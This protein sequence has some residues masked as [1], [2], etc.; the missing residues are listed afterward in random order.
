MLTGLG[1]ILM[2]V[3]SVMMWWRRRPQGVLG[4]PE[5]SPNSKVSFWLG[6]LIL[7]FGIYLPLFGISLIAVKLIEKLILSRVP[8]V[9]DW[10]GL[11][12][13]AG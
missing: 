4:A 6:V 7:M 12:V 5:L 1:L 10:L 2:S 11:T 9:R 3:S 13:A 8:A